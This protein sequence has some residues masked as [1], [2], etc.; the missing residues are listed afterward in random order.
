MSNTDPDKS[1]TAA[2]TAAPADA[3]PSA[4]PGA[5]PRRTPR[6]P[7]PAVVLTLLA[8]CIAAAAAATAWLGAWPYEI[9]SS[10]Y[11]GDVSVALMAA[12]RTVAMIAGSVT[13]GAAVFAA[14]FVGHSPDGL[15]GGRG[16][17]AT[18]L[19]ARAAAVW[20]PAAFVM[21]F[22]TSADGAGIS[23]P[24]MLERNA[25]VEVY[26]AVEQPKSWTVAF[27]LAAVAAVVLR[28][29]LRWVTVLATLGLSLP[30]AVAPGT[31]G[32]NGQ[33]LSH[34]LATNFL[35]LHSAAAAVWLGVLVAA[36]SCLRAAGPGATADEVLR[37]VRWWTVGAVVLLGG[38][39][40][41]ITWLQVRGG[42]LTSSDYGAAAL[43]QAA[44]TALLAVV[45]LT[46]A[47]RAAKPGAGPRRLL[48]DLVLVLA[49]FAA[50]AFAARIPSPSLLHT[51]TT[52][53]EIYIGYDVPG[54]WTW[55]GLV[56][57][58]R[59]DALWLTIAVVMLAGYLLAVRRLHRTGG[60]WPASSTWL[61]A[62]GWALIALS[63]SS[64]VNTWSSAQF[65]MHMVLHLIL[66]LAAAPMLV[67]AA[68]FDL[69]RTATPPRPG[70]MAGPREWADT[71]VHSGLVRVLTTPWVALTIYVL[72]LF[73]FYF[74][75][76][77]DDVIRYHWG[78]QWMNFHFLVTG[79]LFFWPVVGT[80]LPERRL[81]NLGR[82][83]MLLAIMPFHALFGII[84]MTSDTVLGNTFYQAFDLLDHDALLHD[85]MIGGLLAWISG[86]IPVLIAVAILLV[87]WFRREYRANGPG[88]LSGGPDSA[89]AA[90]ESDGAEA[91]LDELQR[92]R[93]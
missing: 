13:V 43:V 54:P 20:A 24:E 76:L 55:T 33:G 67:A 19:A 41:G 87:R 7:G 18:R 48:P 60:A 66:N 68:P 1:T 52:G 74:T 72:T 58:W 89:S 21:I 37:R 80:D 69:I 59:V 26:A 70:G 16:Y 46:R 42:D 32:N 22:L 30:A 65:S 39:G 93:R 53:H 3:P 14:F 83:G 71:F 45:A 47:R 11:P 34:D 35:I 27:V 62:A 17:A 4:Q 61:W 5:A 44:A 50:A 2:R 77:F 25:F 40:A 82:I 49:A 79:C 23:V 28:M 88:Q 31:V 92:L 12:V 38:S 86:E 56:T 51:A 85:Q 63:T 78:H 91:L 10:L 75:P 36:W 9:V 29:A 84:V 6:S 73:G 57:Q 8:L 90:E 15:L 64:G 81:G